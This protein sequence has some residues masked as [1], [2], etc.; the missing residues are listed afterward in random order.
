[1]PPCTRTG[2][3]SRLR[4]PEAPYGRRRLWT[5]VVELR[6]MAP[7]CIVLGGMLNTLISNDAQEVAD[8]AMDLIT[9]IR[10]GGI[11]RNTVVYN[12]LIVA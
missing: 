10:K 3:P 4:R 5:G 2:P 9:S 8:R 12:A 11:A 1:M 6:G 7:H